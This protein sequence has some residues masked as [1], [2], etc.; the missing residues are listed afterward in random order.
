[1]SMHASASRPRQPRVKILEQLGKPLKNG[2]ATKSH[3]I[4]PAFIG[5]AALHIKSSPAFGPALDR[6]GEN[7]V[8]FGRIG[9]THL[10]RPFRTAQKP[11]VQT[12]GMRPNFTRHKAIRPPQQL[13]MIII[14]NMWLT[15]EIELRQRQGATFYVAGIE[16]YQSLKIALIRN[17]HS[18][19]VA[20]KCLSIR[21][22]Q[23]GR[24]RL[25]RQAPPLTSHMRHH[26]MRNLAFHP[27]KPLNINPLVE[28]EPVLL[29]GKREVQCK[30][31]RV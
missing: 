14:E 4:L 3:A 11:I 20:V 26:A 13:Q 29:P 2:I 30:A 31:L 17:P 22:L 21:V 6:L 15:L 5:I 28:Q 12:I 16:P 10:D 23:N 18:L 24:Q 19:E 7:P 8:D 25:A 1:M 9:L 27:Q